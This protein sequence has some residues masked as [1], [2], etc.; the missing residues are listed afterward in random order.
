MFELLLFTKQQEA[1][2]LNGRI[3]T[4]LNH[5]S[6]S[7]S[8]FYVAVFYLDKDMKSG[9]YVFDHESEIMALK[10]PYIVTPVLRSA[11]LCKCNNVLH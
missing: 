3:L 7:N 6:S 4:T 11:V 1:L 2:T 8:A 10:A 5:H 9:L